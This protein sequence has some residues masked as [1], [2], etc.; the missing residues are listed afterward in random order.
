VP[1][2]LKRH[3]APALAW[4]VMAHLV[5]YPQTVGSE[6]PP[7]GPSSGARPQ[8][9][10]SW[11]EIASHLGRGIRTVQRWEREEGL[12]VHRLSHVKRGTVYA[13]G[14][15]LT[16]WWERR[17]RAPAERSA[18]PEAERRTLP[19][20]VRVTSTSAVTFSPSFSSDG[21]MIA[22]VSDAGQDGETPQIWLQQIGG[23]AIRVTS[24]QC[25]C[26]D[27][28]FSHDDTR[29]IFT[30]QGSGSLNLY[31]T[32][33]FGGT[34]RLL[35]RAAKSGRLSPDGRSLAYVSLEAPHGV[36]VAAADGTGD[37]I[38]GDL[39]DPSFV[40]WSP[41]SR[42]LL[43]HG[44]P[45]AD[46][47]PDY[48]II[49]VDGGPGV[50]TGVLQRSRE[51]GL[52]VVS[53][54]PAWTAG[55]VIFAAA[56]RN[57]VGVFRQRLDRN[58]SHAV[59]TPEPL[60]R[61]TELSWHPTV[62][63]G[64]LAFVSAHGDMNLWSIAIDAASGESYGP[65]RRLTRGPGI[66]SH[67]TVTADGR[68]LAYFSSRGGDA[69][70]YV[71]DLDS[72]S[73]TIVSTEPAGVGKGFPALSPSGRQLAFGVRMT[74]PRASRPLFV[75]DLT[76]GR[77]RQICENCGARSRQWL[78][79]RYVIVETFGSRLN[80]F[81]VIDT[82]DGSQRDLLGSADRSLSNPRVSPDGRWLAFDATTPGRVPSV[83]V[84][85]FSLTSTPRETKWIVVDAG[86]SHPFWSRD[87]RLLYYLA[88]TPTVELRSQV[89]ARR[90]A[91]DSGA[92]E[93]DAFTVL[94]LRETLATTVVTGTAP[95]AAPDQIL[96]VLGDV[97]GDIW[98]MDLD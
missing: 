22:Y 57:G 8:R 14:A 78:D 13:D 54:P 44:H 92:P 48:W 73:E 52:F 15:E 31:E 75:A 49:P 27:P 65:L 2:S 55:G 88:T 12:P 9:L 64:R 63:A 21:K 38:V 84:A 86:A 33:A 91:K 97:R 94:T 96:L 19:Q 6:T 3:D 80:R 71:R 76:T 67:L 5:R 35:K 32:P 51:L 83:I 95:I 50:N 45:R 53:S 34:P 17:S 72:G 7:K 26:A 98:M 61:G 93:G 30:A 69:D 68:M 82:M 24:G 4:R 42:Q 39:T 16:A 10:D 74:G 85:P 23:T 28:S 58:E 89:R 79:E 66:L 18:G 56:G 25:E 59:G 47:E 29:I 40:V 70:V 11:K 46:L 60:S 20:L 62:A 1:L 81:L 87:G 77:S 41:T 43:V 37:R 90:M 36:R